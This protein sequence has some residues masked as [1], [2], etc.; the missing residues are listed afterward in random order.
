MLADKASDCADTGQ[1]NRMTHGKVGVYETKP[2]YPDSPPTKIEDERTDRKDRS[3][4]P[5]SFSSNISDLDPCSEKSGADSD[6]EY[7]NCHSK[8][9]YCRSPSPKVKDNQSENIRRYRTA[10]TKEQINLLEKEFLRENYVS[11][12][13]RCELATALNLPESTIKVWFQNRRMKDKRQRM[14]VTW[15]YG[16]P[17]DPAVYAYFAAAAAA[18]YPYSFPNPASL[19]CHSVGLPG[20]NSSG[21]SAFTPFTSHGPLQSRL[22]ILQSMANPLQRSSSAL[23][24]SLSSEASSIGCCLNLSQR[25]PWTEVSSSIHG[26]SPIKS[27][28]CGVPS[29]SMSSSHPGFPIVPGFIP[30]SLGLHPASVLQKAEVKQS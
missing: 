4:S 12:P 15:P 8:S 1:K 28:P 18:T 29:C 13:K 6:T 24:S 26:P 10:F 21:T 17:P 11:R 27:C 20:L 25:L 14:A 9:Q 2:L 5:S 19:P 22:E 16:I 23:N 30:I 7:E 3:L